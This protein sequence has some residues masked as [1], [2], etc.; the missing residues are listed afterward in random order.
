L[1]ESTEEFN[2][3]IPIYLN[4]FTY[5]GADIL[6]QDERKD[7][8]LIEQN[9]NESF[10]GGIQKLRVYNK[11]LTP[12]EVLHNALYEMN[13]NSSLNIRVTKGGRIIYR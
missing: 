8:L 9:F 7:N 2:L 4:D 12:A 13:L 11:G 1:L 10:I 3:N 5:K 6:V